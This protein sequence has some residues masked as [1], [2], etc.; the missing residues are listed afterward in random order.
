MPGIRTSRQAR[1]WSQARLIKA[2]EAEAARDGRRLPGAESM[3]VMLSRWENS[4]AVPDEAYRR[5]LCSALDVDEHE[6]GLT[7]DHRAA[8]V[9][10]ALGSDSSCT[11]L[12]EHVQRVMR[13][14]VD[15]DNQLGSGVVLE[16]AEAEARLLV[17][18]VR[19][20]RGPTR[21]ETLMLAS[22]FVEFCGWL[23][24]DAADPESAERWTSLALEIA[25]E[26]G[27]P[28]QLSYVL[29]RKS[30]LLVDAGEPRRALGLADASLRAGDALSPQMRAVTLRQRAMALAAMSEPGECVAALD[31]A[32]SE[33]LRAA[34]SDERVGYVSAPYIGSE[35]GG[36]LVRLERPEQ[37]LPILS[38][39][40]TG[41][42]GGMERDRGLCLTR[43]A[44]ALVSLKEVDLGAAH[45]LSA[46]GVA[47]STSSLRL[48]A[49]IRG[50]GRRLT[51]HRG[52]DTVD[53]V[54]QAITTL[55]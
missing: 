34:A 3:R 18:M 17:G 5:Y 7:T 47:R 55:R 13:E 31:E 11:Y 54:T 39:A 20:V 48:R 43:S 42:P 24:Q 25:E 2:L 50:V 29:M 49:E 27:D 23:R 8:G 46:V 37:A 32:R 1:G 41:W 53:E 26:L 33:V 22:R 6:L 30:N 9:S 21:P 16:A 40:L 15:A 10:G 28:A 14:L 35:A 44:S 36:C 45:L 52:I 19:H 12:I 38:E 4:H 51:P